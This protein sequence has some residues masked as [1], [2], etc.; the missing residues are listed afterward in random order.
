MR[1]IDSAS[2]SSGNPN[3]SA[4]PI[5]KSRV[6]A[7]I[8]DVTISP[9]VDIIVIITNISQKIGVRSI[10]AGVKLAPAWLGP[11]RRLGRHAHARA[12]EI[13]GAFQRRMIAGHGVQ[14]QSQQV[15]V[16]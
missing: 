2:G 9:A 13:L 6:N 1:S 15:F 14:R 4:F 12:F 8:C 3:T 5:P 10:S 7:A 11:D 16:R